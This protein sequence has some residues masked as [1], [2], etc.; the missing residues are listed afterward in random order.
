MRARNIVVLAA[1]TVV[2]IVAA[3]LAARWR[4]PDELAPREL[5]YPDLRA[6]VNEVAEIRIEGKGRAVT[7]LRDGERWGIREADNYPALFEKVKQ[8]AVGL[9]ELRLIEPKTSNPE[10]YVRLGVE[11]PSAA[12]ANSMLLTLR[13]AN[14]GELAQLIVGRNRMSRAAGG[15]PGLY[16]RRPGAAQALLVEG[17][18]DATSNPFD[19]FDRDL[20]DIRDERIRLIEITQPDGER[21]RLERGER[22]APLALLDPPA[23][24]EVQSEILL[25]RMGTLLEGMFADGVRS[26]AATQLPAEATRATVLT[27]DGLAV[28]VRTARFDGAGLAEFS[29][30]FDALAAGETAPAAAAEAEPATDAAAQPDVA[31]EAAALNARLGGW[32]FEIPDYRFE[33]LTRRVADLVQEPGANKSGPAALP[34]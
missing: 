31:A 22:G 32:L 24:K 29:F 9:A 26:A 18:I 17:R 15:A 28:E 7:L 23:G 14:G 1:V 5:L 33:L 2:L 3:V 27:F 12:G 13:D 20:F 19:W 16:V 4:A 21:L 8:V 11:D 10:F 30:R 25:G 34:Q 6:R